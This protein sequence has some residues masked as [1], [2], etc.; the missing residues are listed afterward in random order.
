MLASLD[1]KG[2]ERYWDENEKFEVTDMSM[3][4]IVV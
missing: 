1:A 4:H 2:W 3:Y